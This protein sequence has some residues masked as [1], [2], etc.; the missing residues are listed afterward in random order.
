MKELQMTESLEV[1]NPLPKNDAPARSPAQTRAEA[2]M[3]MVELH[4]QP[5]TRYVNRLAGRHDQAQDIVQECFMRL[6]LHWGDSPIPPVRNVKAWLFTV[7][8]NLAM[9][10][11][12]KRKSGLVAKRNLAQ[13][14]CVQ[15]ADVATTFEQ[16]ETTRAAMAALDALPDDYKQVVHLKVIEGMT[17]R[18]ISKITGLSLGCI[19]HRL[20]Q[21]IGALAG[22]MKRSGH[23]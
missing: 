8:H 21:A 16:D 22:Q 19:N 20:N 2:F 9:D 17:F 15:T 1:R 13:A 12:R 3:G 4:H 5:L 14:Q 11:I 6:H 10:L 23:S 7:A 18:Q